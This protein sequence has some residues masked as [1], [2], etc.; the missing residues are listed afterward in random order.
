MK[1]ILFIIIS[2]GITVLASAQVTTRPVCD[3]AAEIPYNL[4]YTGFIIQD[5]SADVSV[6]EN[7][8]LVRLEISSGSP[9]GNVRYSKNFEVPYSRSGFFS[10][11]LGG[12]NDF[13]FVRFVE[14]INEGSGSLDLFFDVYFSEGLSGNY[15]YIGSKPINAVPYAF[16]ANAVGGIGESG[17]PGPQ[18]PAGAAGP[19]GQQGLSGAQ[20][21][22]GA[23]GVQ[24]DQG[25]GIMVMR[26][27]PPSDK[28]MY[29]DDGTNTADGKPHVRYKFNGNWID[30]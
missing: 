29:V 10:I 4:T 24:G 17:V 9:Q 18:G 3:E 30:L 7:N 15:T 28:N 13:D 19:V 26:S 25:F 21:E 11:E 22:P 23:A 27:S 1:K 6:T 12:T 20:G 16:V 5:E 8:N 2:L 14:D